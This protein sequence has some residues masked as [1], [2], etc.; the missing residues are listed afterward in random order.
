MNNLI[1][2]LKN[3]GLQGG[4]VYTGTPT[5]LRMPPRDQA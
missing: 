2:D 5:F 4:P 1:S 3:K